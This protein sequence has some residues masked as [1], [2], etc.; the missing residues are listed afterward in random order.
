MANKTWDNNATF[1]IDQS[2]IHGRFSDREYAAKKRLTRRDRFRAEID[3]VTPWSQLHHQC[4]GTAP[5]CCNKPSISGWP[6]SS[7]N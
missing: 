3:K 7:T 6:R 4:D 2:T 5:I 1:S